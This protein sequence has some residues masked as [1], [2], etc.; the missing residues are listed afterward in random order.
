MLNGNARLEFNVIY[1]VV[2]PTQITNPIIV[3]DETKESKKSPAVVLPDTHEELKENLKESREKKK[4]G[5][6]K[7]SKKTTTADKENEEHQGRK[8]R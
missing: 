5:S 1:V 8:F 2:P 4:T 6:Q 3:E 7:G